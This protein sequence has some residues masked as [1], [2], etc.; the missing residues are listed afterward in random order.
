MSK[1]PDASINFDQFTC[2]GV[3]VVDF[4][5]PWCGPCSLLEP[6]LDE[7]AAKL[8]EVKF[9]KVNCDK[10]PELVKQYQV[11]SIPNICI[12]KDGKLVDRIVGLCDEDELTDAIEAHL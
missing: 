5:A 9:G 7:V 4:W 6:V 1:Y 3:V 8:P 10:A 11:V 12:F 2:H